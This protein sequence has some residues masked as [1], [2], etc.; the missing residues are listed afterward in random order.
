M[1]PHTNKAMALIKVQKPF[2]KQNLKQNWQ[3]GNGLK[4][5]FQKATSKGKGAGAGGEVNTKTG[6]V[7]VSFTLDGEAR[8]EGTVGLYR[9]WSGYGFVELNDKGIV[10]DDKVF[11]YW[12]SIQSDDRFPSLQQGMQVEFGIAKWKDN[13]SSKYQL[14]AKMVTLPGGASISLQDE[15]D[16]EKKE[17]VGGQYLRYTGTLKFFCPERGF[18]YIAMDEGYQVPDDVP[19]E[20]RVELAEVNAGAK[21]PRYMKDIQVE[22]GIWKTPKGAY[23]AYNMT[24]PGGIPMVQEGLE[25]RQVLVA[26]TYEGTV[27]MWNWRQGWGYIKLEGS[28]GL[29]A[30][31]MAK[32]KHMYA[33]TRARGKE[34]GDPSGK[35]LYFRKS[36]VQRGVRIDKG[37]KVTFQIYTDDKGAGACEVH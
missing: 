33:A 2:L 37:Q 18:G 9:K 15:M 31:V 30:S 14:R 26:R 35:T 27:D 13:G 20:I 6:L 5:F 17:F 11:V 16:A 12:K 8:Y 4:G 10:P 23:K 25:H 7:D 34:V 1:T 22:F 29:P 28:V 19:N 3:K 21:Q 32:I 36:D 24:L